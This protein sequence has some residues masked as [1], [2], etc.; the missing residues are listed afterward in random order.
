MYS[1]RIRKEGE[2]SKLDRDIKSFYSGN[3]STTDFICK[4]WNDCWD[5]LL[6]YVKQSGFNMRYGKLPQ[7]LLNKQNEYEQELIKFYCENTIEMEIGNQYFKEIEQE[8][9]EACIQYL[10]DT[11]QFSCRSIKETIRLYIMGKIPEIPKRPISKGIPKKDKSEKP[12]WYIPWKRSKELKPLIRSAYSGRRSMEELIAVYPGTWGELLE[13]IVVVKKLNSISDLS[14][15]FLCKKEE[16]EEIVLRAFGK[17]YCDM[18][19]IPVDEQY[20]HPTEDDVRI[21]YEFLQRERLGIGRRIMNQTI[22]KYIRGEIDIVQNTQSTE[23]DEID[24]SPMREQRSKC[25]MLEAKLQQLQQNL[26]SKKSRLQQLRTELSQPNMD[27][28]KIKKVAAEIMEIA[29][30]V[31]EIQTQIDGIDTKK[32]TEEQQLANMKENAIKTIQEI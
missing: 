30:Q 22:S 7:A 27:M 9:I 3:M 15:S 20:I 17:E 11:N 5:S 2:L 16:F 1:H 10:I 24:L 18:T 29:Q 19:Q 32:L 31:E 23:K 25:Q 8:D 6:E 13:D 4:C 26:G 28:K 21:V 12:E 14:D